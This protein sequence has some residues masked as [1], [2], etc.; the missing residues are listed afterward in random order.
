MQYLKTVL[1]PAHRFS[2]ALLLLILFV[3]L[4]RAIPAYAGGTKEY[5]NPD[6]GYWAVIEDEADLLTEEEEAALLQE[7]IPVTAFGHAAFRSVSQNTMAADAYAERFYHS[8]FGKDSGTLFLIDMDNRRLEFFSDGAAYRTI[9]KSKARTIA[10]NIYRDAT[11]GRYYACASS[12]FRQVATLLQG[13]RISEPMRYIG[14]GFLALILALLMN[15]V[16]VNTVTKI[17]RIS[18]DELVQVA[19]SEITL[20]YAEGV[21]TGETQRYDP[22]E[23]GGGGGSSGGGGGGGSGSSGGGGGHSF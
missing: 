3:F 18:S 16:L 2:P 11:G 17:R 22:V 10:D 1:K 14:N 4:F 19:K 6:T 13:G 12:A 7:M 8:T 21:Y 20:D 15:F 5:R 9:T 23:R